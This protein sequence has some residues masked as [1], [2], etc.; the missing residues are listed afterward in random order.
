MA[1]MKMQV[2]CACRHRM[3]LEVGI[4]SQRD[5]E[6]LKN[7]LAGLPRVPEVSIHIR[8]GKDFEF[9]FSD[10]EPCRNKQYVD[11]AVSLLDALPGISVVVHDESDPHARTL[12]ASGMEA[13]AGACRAIDPSLMRRGKILYVEFSGRLVPRDYIGLMESIRATGIGSVGACIDTGHVYYYYRKKVGQRRGKAVESMSRFIGEVRATGVPVSYHV[14][15]CTP[16]S[17]HPRYHVFDHRPV[18]E[19]EIGLGGFRRIAGYLAGEK[20][21]LEIL[22]LPDPG[23]NALTDEEVGLLTGYAASHGI[24]E[25]RELRNGRI[26]KR[27][28]EAMVESRR[29]LDDLLA[30]L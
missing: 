20:V 26:M 24:D 1:L 30:S 8:R 7:F 4:R 2:R 22:P 14:H 27:T 11:A 5:L 29:I 25:G 16:E 19:G 28:L 3:G 15:D 18:G 13:Y 10:D 17:P 9:Y 6:I 21:T 12:S 23:K